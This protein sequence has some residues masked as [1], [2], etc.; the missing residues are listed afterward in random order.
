MG[1]PRAVRALSRLIIKE[2]P[3][4]VFLMETRLKSS[5]MVPL[6]HK[7]G[8][9]CGLSVDCRGIGRERAGGVSLLW[10]DNMDIT[11]MSY[12]ANHIHGQC[13]DEEENEKWDI[14][15]IYG[16][17]EEN[18]KRKTWQLLEKLTSQVGRKW[19]C[20]GDF[21]D[22]LSAE[23][24]IG[25]N[26]R[27]QSQLAL[28]RNALNVCNLFDMGFEGYQY[29]WSNGREGQDNIQCRLDRVLCSDDF[30][31]RFSP[32][33]VLHL[34]RFGSDHVAILTTLE[35]PLIRDAGRRKHIFRFE[36]SWTKEQRCENIIK[37]CW[38]KPHLS[39]CERIELLQDMGKEFTDHNVGTLRKEINEVEK[40]LKDVN[41][42][43]DTVEAINRYKGMEKYHE[44]LLK[45]EEVMW[46]QRSRAVWLKDGD[47]NTKFFHTKASQRRRVNEIK[48]LKD[49]TGNSCRGEENVERLLI[50]YFNNLFTTSNPS[51]VEETSEVVRGKLS[52]SQI[53]WCE[54]EFTDE[55][56]FEAIHQ[57]HPLKAPGPDGLPALFFQKY[58]HI[59]G[60]DVQ[61][62]ALQ[63]LNNNLEPN[64]LNK[65]FIVL[66]P[67]GKN[68]TSPKDYRPISLC[69]VVM[70][71]I[72]KV[73]ANRV[74]QTL[75]EVIDMEQS[76]FVQGRLITDNALIAMECFHWLKKKRKGKKGV[77]ALKLDMS[78]AYDRLEWSFVEQVLKSMCFLLRMVELIMKCIT[79]VSYQIL[80]NGQPSSPFTP[81]R[82]L[83]QGDPLSPYL[84]VL[85]ADVL[86]GL[87]RAEVTSQNIHGVKIARTA[88]Q[89][90]HLFFADDILLF[91][92]A[93][94]S[95]AEK[96]MSI[97]TRYKRAS[98]QVVNLDKSEATF[99]RNVPSE[100]I[101]TICEIMGVK[102][103]E[104][105]SRYLGFPVPFGRSKKVIFTGVMDRVWKKLKGW[106]ERFL[107]RAGKETLIK[108]VAQ[109][110]PNYILSWYKLPEGC[111]ND[112]DS[113]LA[114][115]WWGSKEEERKIHW[116]SWAKLSKAKERGGLGFRGFS[117][118]NK[119]L[120]GKHCWRLSN[121]DD[122]LLGKVLKSRYY[123]RVPFLEAKAGYQP[124]YGW[125][126]IISAREVVKEGGRWKKY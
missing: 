96:I 78:K 102:A 31:T 67:K 21:N 61:K 88:P 42:W 33:K 116:M 75:P 99:S 72:T 83:R 79:T 103:V 32:V 36:E 110:I 4:I 23:E 89:I 25:G 105:Q 41:S 57:M 69:N 48:K 38:G 71:I 58:W 100:D 50:S 20:M 108:A 11:I 80:I 93:N 13:V 120:L 113:M 53:L 98:G 6:R 94:K 117:D 44:E 19:M 59:V 10:R 114:K 76:A 106:K 7:W 45:Q 30:T 2:K 115:F 107:S 101:Q 74:K 109:A 91:S 73:I 51:D 54:K 60:R 125:R 65:T 34:P 126:S 55:E 111:C 3:H 92:K 87:I 82:G 40:R 1:S 122:S 15:G 68:P 62:F 24:K 124:S 5:E 43:E 52:Q 35:A 9:N 64:N 17:P 123:P 119:A 97:L 29:T 39:C 18:N 90:S 85:C 12:S 22:V 16:H 28:G 81:E 112:I 66:I 118:F 26:A 77:M 47:K 84:F 104:A 27:T 49:E 95:E 63:V 14:T 70:K 37:Y 121:R 86:S 8:F 56:V 46:R